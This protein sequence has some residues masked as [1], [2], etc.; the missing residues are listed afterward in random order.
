MINNF[1]ACEQ[2]EL[3]DNVHSQATPSDTIAL[4]FLI[5]KLDLD[6]LSANYQSDAQE[7]I[8]TSLIDS[9]LSTSITRIISLLKAASSTNEATAAN[10]PQF[11]NFATAAIYLP[12]LLLSS[13]EP[14]T[15]REL[16]YALFSET[17]SDGA[18]E[19]YGQNHANLAM[20]LGLAALTKVDRKKVYCP[21]PLTAKYCQLDQSEKM[22]LLQRLC[23]RIPIIQVA[24]KCCASDD[25]ID[26]CMKK[27]LAEST[28][29][30]RRSNVLE[31]LAF[32][33]G[34]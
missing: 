21:T 32:A 18:A 16:G 2:K 13:D 6:F 10:I 19:K 7:K 34:E 8:I 17:K 23:F 11:S 14:L 4:Q 9:L 25:A 29:L 27:T 20:Q 31:V 24:V 1:L 30:R 5:G 22:E 12:E 3:W 28:Y 33:L 26:E 15:N